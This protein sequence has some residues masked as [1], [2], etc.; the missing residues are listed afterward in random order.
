MLVVV[1]S[2]AA[3]YVVFSG[4]LDKTGDT[5]NDAPA[6]SGPVT[7]QVYQQAMKETTADVSRLTAAGDEKSIKQ[8]EKIINEQVE[9]AAQSG[10]EE[11]SVEAQL[12]K[13]DFL[14]TNGRPQEALDTIL[15]PL[16]E[17]YFG[18]ETYIYSI[19]GSMSLAY[20]WLDDLEKANE[21]LNKMPSQ[22]WN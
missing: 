6:P 15:T 3:A 2:G 22:G 13:A 14:S 4:M 11:Y 9:K 10:N 17:K 12:A 20:R 16:S 5:A 19:Y 1:L 21:Y 18:N 7:K 8:A